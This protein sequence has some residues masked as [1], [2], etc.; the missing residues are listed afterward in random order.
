MSEAGP[1]WRPCRA[2]VKCDDGSPDIDDDSAEIEIAAG[3][4]LLVYFDE[5]G[6]VVLQG[7]EEAPGRFACR[8]RSRPRLA[9]LTRTG[10]VLEGHWR[11]GDESGSLRIELEVACGDQEESPR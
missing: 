8:A 6:A 9:Q 5:R 7:R 3:G 11:E 4:L 1:D 2:I 10:R